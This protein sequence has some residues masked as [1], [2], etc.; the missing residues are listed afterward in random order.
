MRYEEIEVFLSTEEI[1]A[2][3]VLE[4]CG[5]EILTETKIEDTYRKTGGRIRTFALEG[6]FD[7]CAACKKVDQL[8]PVE[9]SQ[10][11]ID[12]ETQETVEETTL[13][14]TVDIV[15]DGQMFWMDKKN[16][17]MLSRDA[18]R[19]LVEDNVEDLKKCPDAIQGEVYKKW[20]RFFKS[21]DWP[22]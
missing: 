7:I 15:P 19:E 5:W 20:T 4:G 10:E 3:E 9:G 6:R 17:K 1:S 16:W 11:T 14:E 22:L 8:I 18:F 2:L 12:E 21:K 13:P